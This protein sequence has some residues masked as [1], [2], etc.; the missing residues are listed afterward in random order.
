[1]SYFINQAQR[2]LKIV[3]PNVPE[4]EIVLTHFKG[5]QSLSCPFEFMCDGI[6]TSEGGGIID[7]LIGQ[8]AFVTI[9][10]A[11]GEKEYFNG[12]ITQ[13][14][15]SAAKKSKQVA[16][17]FKISP[18]F[19][20]LMQNSD[21]RHFIELSVIDII[22]LLLKECENNAYECQL[23]KSYPKIAF[24][25]QYNESTWD[26][27]ARLISETGIFYTIIHSNEQ[28]K[29]IFYDDVAT[30]PNYPQDCYVRNSDDNQAHFHF[31]QS[32]TAIM[33]TKTEVQ[34]YDFQSPTQ[35]FIATTSSKQNLLFGEFQFW[36][37][38]SKQN[39]A[40]QKTAELIQ[41]FFDWQANQIKVK[42]NYPK[43]RAGQRF[44]L[45]SNTHNIE[46]YYIQH[47][48]YQ[49]SDTSH[50]SD[51]HEIQ[52]S[53]QLYQNQLTVIPTSFPY[54]MKIINKPKIKGV[55]SATVTTPKGKVVACDPY[56]RVKIQFPWDRRSQFNEHSSTWV[57]TANPIAGKEW[58]M[59][60]IPRKGDEVLIQ[61]CHQNID[62]PMIIG[63]VYNGVNSPIYPLPESQQ[64]SG[65]KT[66]TIGS[67]ES[68][69]FN[70]IR[71]DDSAHQE[72][73][74]LKAQRDNNITTNNDYVT[75]IVKDQNINIEQ[76]NTLATKGTSTL[77]SQNT[78]HLTAGKAELKLAPDK[79]ELKGILINIE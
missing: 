6:S 36:P 66:H 15:K 9:N 47:I 65:I 62:E 29:V 16:W 39:D 57:R 22:N 27:I 45:K 1:M 72:L 61:Y 32:S 25:V 11:K 70:E 68:D 51:S 13:V 37:N 40:N 31:W 35:Q 26:F 42:G 10:H 64:V 4:N 49:I 69:H 5:Q 17:R 50:L 78:F 54:A 30:L 48:Q 20:P 2:L 60:F 71:F 33:P 38:D 44:N 63:S 23:T 24:T 79:I 73:L 52:P 3:I 34:S 67:D 53:V 41:H 58:G 12:L 8:K 56:L 59:K 21:C 19:F 75:T 55:S 28:H 76:A 46:K 14:Q 77:V 74:T 18:W 43:M 7:N